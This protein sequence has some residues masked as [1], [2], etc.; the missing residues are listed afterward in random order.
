MPTRDARPDDTL[1]IDPVSRVP[2]TDWLLVLDAN[3]SGALAASLAGQQPDFD[4]WKWEPDAL[5]RRYSRPGRRL[6]DSA[7]L[8]TK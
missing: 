3:P 1:E 2:L 5:F 6:R 7:P 8:L 4:R